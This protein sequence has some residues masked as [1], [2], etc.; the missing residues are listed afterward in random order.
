MN[1]RTGDQMIQSVKS[2][3]LGIRSLVALVCC[4]LTVEQISRR[5]KWDFSAQ[6]MLR[7]PAV[8]RV[9]SRCRASNQRLQNVRNFG[10]K[11]HRINSIT[12]QVKHTDIQ[13][14]WFCWQGH[15]LLLL[16][17]FSDDGIEAWNVYCYIAWQYRG[18]GRSKSFKY[19][20]GQMWILWN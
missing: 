4:R 5:E 1:S 16:T 11:C 7:S 20:S 14:C 10:S 8:L 17:S 13:A 9:I 19:M 3:R 12:R 15:Q 18:I 2:T 6:K